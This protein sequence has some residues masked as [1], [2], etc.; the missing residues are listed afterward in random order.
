MTF[1]LD[2]EN[3]RDGNYEEKIILPF[4]NEKKDREKRAVQAREVIIVR[5][6]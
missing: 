2:T 1:W 6:I 5:Y 4:I 3:Q